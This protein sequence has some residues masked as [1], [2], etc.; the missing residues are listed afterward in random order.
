MKINEAFLGLKHDDLSIKLCQLIEQDFPGQNERVFNSERC[1]FDCNFLGF[2]DQYY[3][4]SQ[5]IPE[6]YIV[7]DLGCYASSQGYF[8]RNHKQYIGVDLYD[9]QRYKF[10][11]TLNKIQDIGEAIEEYASNQT[12]IFVICNYTS[13]IMGNENNVNIRKTFGNIFNFYPTIRP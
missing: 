13:H 6:E 7:L 5:I 2:L 8:F 11:N 4:L 3:H 1:E 12:N 10:E 9:G